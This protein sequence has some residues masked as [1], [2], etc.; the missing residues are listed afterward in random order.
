MNI[1]II[2]LLKYL[3]LCCLW[4]LIVFPIFK[5]YTSMIA[6]DLKCTVCWQII[7]LTTRGCTYMQKSY[8]QFER[9]QVSLYVLYMTFHY[10]SKSLT[11]IAFLNFE[12]VAFAVNLGVVCTYRSS[13]FFKYGMNDLKSSRVRLGN[14]GSLSLFPLIDFLHCLLWSRRRHGILK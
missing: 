14:Q 1:N 13:E 10:K 6:N 9:Y 5:T 12:L 11:T 2:L 4:V 8:V 7:K 3:Q